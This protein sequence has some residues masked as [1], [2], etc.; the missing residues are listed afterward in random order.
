MTE[1]EWVRGEFRNL[2]F[3]NKSTGDSL[4]SVGCS[5]VRRSL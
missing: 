3:I 1:A 2:Q 4:Y 5:L